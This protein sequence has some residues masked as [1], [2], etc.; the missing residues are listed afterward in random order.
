[1]AHTQST[2]H[3]HPTTGKP[4]LSHLFAPLQPWFKRLENLLGEQAAQL[5]PSVAG[6]ARYVTGNQGKRLRPAL[7]ILGGLCIQ[8]KPDARQQEE[9][10]K[11][12]AILEMIHIATLVHDDILDGAHFRRNQLTATAKW[13]PE[14]AVLLGDCLFAQATLLGTGFSDAII[15]KRIAEITVQVCSGEIMQIQHRF[16]LKLGEQNYLRIIEM[17]TGL[18]FAAC[19][20]LGGHLAGATPENRQHLF[21]FGRLWGAAYQIYDDCVDLVGNEKDIGKSL[22]TD[23]QK[24]KLTLPVILLLQQLPPQEHQ[25]ASSMLLN[26]HA[27]SV[28][29]LLD[30]IRRHGTI[31]QAASKADALLDEARAHLHPFKSSQAAAI[32]NGLANHVSRELQSLK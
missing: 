9:L 10:I 29:M 15:G 6:H 21:S 16:D 23:L 12:S 11:L 31:A 2:I 8:D 27:N 22:G 19:C 26:E 28:G 18:L 20:E 5:A 25:L 7:T 4:R 13:G 1:M 17:K 30:T 24:G 14:V 3:Q 32:L